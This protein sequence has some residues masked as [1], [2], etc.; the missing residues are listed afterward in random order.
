M[1]LLFYLNIL[2]FIIENQ[3]VV[4]YDWSNIRKKIYFDYE[5]INF[6]DKT[7]NIFFL[8]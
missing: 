7:V 2:P 5:I 3:F 1:I 4:K 6:A 8:L